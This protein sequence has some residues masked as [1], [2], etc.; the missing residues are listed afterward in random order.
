[1]Y[2][3]V[4]DR[5]KVDNPN[6]KFLASYCF[7]EE[8]VQSKKQFSMGP[9]QKDIKMRTMAVKVIS[10]T[11]ESIGFSMTTMSMSEVP[12]AMMLG[13]ID[14]GCCASWGEVE[15][16]YLDVA[17]YIYRDRILATTGFLIMNQ[18]IFD[19][20]SAKDQQIIEDVCGDWSDYACNA[21]VENNESIA[22]RV[23]GLGLEVYETTT[24]EWSASARIIIPLVWPQLEEIVGTATMDRIKENARN[25][26]V[27]AQVMEDIGW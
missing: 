6:W 25:N 15:S 14:A 1:M 10:D 11:Y 7:G 3:I 26:P 9:G 23:Q 17:E 22:Q 2:N 24:E 19:S 8:V 16:F 21:I 27:I 18:G 20:L 4:V 13:T 12:S 5:L